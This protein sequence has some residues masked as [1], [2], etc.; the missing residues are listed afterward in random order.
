MSFF[1]QYHRIG[2]DGKKYWGRLGAGIVFTDGKKILLLQRSPKSDHP[3]YWCIPGGKANE[4]ESPID[5]AV[6]ESKEECGSA[7]GIR[8]AQFH[9]RD[10]GHHFH[11]FLYSVMKPFEVRLS[12]EH[13]D[14]AWVPID[15]V[16]KMKLLPKFA[17][18]FPAYLRAIKKRFPEEKS[19]IEWLASRGF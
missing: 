13:S 8:F 4:N 6:R 2:K 11:T 19:F 3:G 9:D 10:G 14:S 12:D 1:E 15:E 17:E 16:K 5:C 7:E 18:S